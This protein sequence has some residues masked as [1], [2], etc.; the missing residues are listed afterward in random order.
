MMMSYRWPLRVSCGWLKRVGTWWPITQRLSEIHLYHCLLL[1]WFPSVLGDYSGYD[2][3][4]L[5]LL[6]RKLV[7][8]CFSKW[9]FFSICAADGQYKGSE[10]GCLPSRQYLIMMRVGALKPVNLSYSLSSSTS[11]LSDF[12]Q[13]T[14][15]KYFSASISLLWS[16]HSATTLRLS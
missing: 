11:Q 15:G 3:F 10:K 8:K 16:R 13:V 12:G 5:T 14:L 2:L 7:C 1:C 9:F 4:L 6:E